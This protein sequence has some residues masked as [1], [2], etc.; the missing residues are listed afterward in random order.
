VRAACTAYLATVL[1]SQLPPDALPGPAGPSRLALIGH[2]VAHSLSPRFQNAA[3]AAAG[4]AVRYETA[5]VDAADLDR[6]IEQ[7]RRD[8]AAGNVTVPH[9]VAFAERC[10]VWSVTAARAGAV[11]TFWVDGAGR[12]VGDN[13]DAGGFSAALRALVPPEQVREVALIGAGG[14][15]A[16]VVAALAEWPGVTVRV[17]SRRT[18]AARALA[19]RFPAIA[20]V[21]LLLDDA[22]AGASLVVNATPLGLHDADPSPIP[23]GRLPSGT[24]VFDLAYA[25]ART[26]WVRA[27]RRAGHV[28]DDGLGMLVEQGAL[29]F[30]RW[31]GRWPDRHAMW[32]A[33]ADV[34]AARV[35]H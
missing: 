18:E 32:G 7:I 34:L 8:G 17:W 25:P 13:T 14:S 35:D 12:L 24:A 26:A 27:A 23:V 9:K 20:S 33:L 22:V 28:A 16:A 29:A 4:L 31:F 10:D 19:T 1:V 30:E 2:P 5:D 21:A 11:N 15:A 3:L 6:V